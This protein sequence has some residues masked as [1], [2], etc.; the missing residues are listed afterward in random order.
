MANIIVHV[1]TTIICYRGRVLKEWICLQF[2]ALTIH[3]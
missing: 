1:F 2:M 3:K